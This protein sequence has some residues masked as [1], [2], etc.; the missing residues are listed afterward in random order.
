MTLPRHGQW[1]GDEVIL[2]V[3]V[4]HIE[5]TSKFKFRMDML[6]SE[7]ID[8]IRDS[9][10]KK[11]LLFGADLESTYTLFTLGGRGGGGTM[12]RTGSLFAMKSQESLAEYCFIP[13][14][15]LYFKPLFTPS[16]ATV[17]AAAA[18]VDADSMSAPSPVPSQPVMR[19]SFTQRAALPAPIADSNSLHQLAQSGDHARIQEVLAASKIAVDHQDVHGNTALMWAGARGHPDVVQ[20]LLRAGASVDLQSKSGATALLYS[21][22]KG[23]AD[24][25]RALI[26]AQANPN[27]RDATGNSPVST[28]SKNGH[29][30]IVRDL[31]SHGADV[32]A[33]DTTALLWASKKGHLDIVRMLLAAGAD[34]LVATAEGKTALDLAR[35]HPAIVDVLRAWGP[36]LV[37]LTPAEIE[38]GD[39]NSLVTV[40]IRNYGTGTTISIDGVEMVTTELRR[41]PGDVVSVQF[42]AP[43]SD[44]PCFRHIELAHAT[45]AR[46]V[47]QRALRYGQPSQEAAASLRIGKFD[48]DAGYVPPPLP[49]SVAGSSSAPPSP[50]VPPSQ[51]E[52]PAPAPP[53]A[54]A[55]PPPSRPPIARRSLST[56]MRGPGP[57]RAPPQAPDGGPP[58]APMRKV[59]STPSLAA[60]GRT[61]PPTPRGGSIAPPEPPLDDA[62]GPPP[63]R[64]QMPPPPQSE[65]SGRRPELQRTSPMSIMRQSLVVQS[66]TTSADNNVGSLDRRSSLQSGTSG[67]RASSVDPLI[68]PPGSPRTGHKQ[69]SKPTDVHRNR[70]AVKAM[71]AQAGVDASI[72]DR[73]PGT[74]QPSANPN[75]GAA[76]GAAAPSGSGD[77]SVMSLEKSA[78]YAGGFSDTHSTILWLWDALHA[79][80]SMELSTFSHMMT[81]NAQKMPTTIRISKGAAGASISV[82]DTGGA[83]PTLVLPVFASKKELV[84]SLKNELKRS[85][86]AAMTN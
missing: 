30:E 77:V 37:R 36:E 24:C 4:P 52:A 69:F 67:V 22:R 54:A 20:Q 56:S 62:V 34:K 71:L 12:R 68:S 60:P 35:P 81:G 76:G 82:T 2:T 73:K 9:L 43:P 18:P 49:P 45:G 84:D 27:L 74:F 70:D 13:G 59:G 57:S 66:T 28:A 44:F 58:D 32:N 85:F 21:A 51:P 42:Q 46:C 83:Q 3:N 63:M 11:G 65:N 75:F 25:V 10:Q 14:D 19:A 41:A 15:M 50:R 39:E 86:M 23:R 55:A 31:L 79:M 61:L 33:R 80:S 7:A 16:A 40:D 17:A 53:L 6:V 38:L 48:Q 26:A 47:A 64:P 78:V 72:V 5:A 8:H 1:T 29:A